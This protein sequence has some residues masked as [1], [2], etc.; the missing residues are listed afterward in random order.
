MNPHTSNTFRSC[1]RILAYTSRTSASVVGTAI[2][3]ESK[4]NG[5]IRRLLVTVLPFLRLT[6]DTFP[7]VKAPLAFSSR[8]FR[9]SNDSS[10]FLRDAR[11]LKVTSAVDGY[12]ADTSEDENLWMSRILMAFMFGV[13]DVGNSVAIHFE[14]FAYAPPSSTS[15]QNDQY[16]LV[17]MSTRDLPE[18][19]YSKIKGRLLSASIIPAISG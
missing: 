14:N 1:D 11:R 10:T 13:A 18:I 3:I 19:M 15:R 8:F 4:G 5:S 7:P 12:L 16:Y 6:G 2:P 17:T 9:T